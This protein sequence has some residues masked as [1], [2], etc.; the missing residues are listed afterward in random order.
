M[1]RTPLQFFDPAQVD[2]RLGLF[3]SIFKPIEAVEPACHHPG[4]VPVLLEKLL[5]VRNGAGLKQLER[6]HY[7]S[8]YG[9]NFLR[10]KSRS[11][12]FG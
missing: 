9:H 6:R 12:E 1:V 8:Y 5:S 10:F 3:D 7:I 11:N 4:L 2:Q